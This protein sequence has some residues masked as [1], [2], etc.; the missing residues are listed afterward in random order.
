MTKKNL[1]AAG[2]SGDTLLGAGE[3]VLAFDV[4]GTDTKAALVDEHGALRETLRI[5]TRI[6]GARTADH[7]IE[8][9]TILARELGERHPE[10]APAAAGLLVPGTVDDDGGVGIYSENLKWREYPFRERAAAALGLPVGFGHDVRWAG[11][12]EFRLGAARDYDDVLVVTIGTG[13]AAAV[14]IGGRLYSG[15]GYA[16]EI[17]HDRVGDGPECS[18]GGIG[19]LEAIASAASIARRYTARTGIAVQGAREVLERKHRG[20]QNAAAAWETALDALA[21]GFSHAVA[22]L[23]PQAIVVGGGL[24]EA[25]DELLQPLRERLEGILTIHR[26]PEI[27]RARIG[28][29]AGVIGSALRAR[30]AAT[31]ARF[32]GETRASASG[33]SR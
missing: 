25:G 30:D 4:G 5:P 28:E 1:H 27:I 26:R 23:A 11:V 22:L 10:V 14:F 16:G 24:S 21:L 20:D 15:G 2:S 13:I 31:A 29:D 12:A 9:L 19:C 7:V 3:A 18:C 32:G 33:G 8:D 17:G 6:D